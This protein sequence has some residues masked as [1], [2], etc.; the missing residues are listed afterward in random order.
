MK[1]PTIEILCHIYYVAPYGA[2]NTL[3]QLTVPMTVNLNSKSISTAKSRAKKFAMAD[4]IP[5]YRIVDIT[6]EERT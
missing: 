3:S 5:T 4:G 1:T 2:G 6:V